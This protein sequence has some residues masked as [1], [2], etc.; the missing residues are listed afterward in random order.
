MLDILYV[1]IWR[2]MHLEAH[3]SGHACVSEVDPKSQ[4]P[5]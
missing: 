1:G 5:V 3:E 4:L 2:E